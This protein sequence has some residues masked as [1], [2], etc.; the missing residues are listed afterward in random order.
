[1]CVFERARVGKQSEIARKRRRDIVG[2]REREH[3]RE[4]ARAKKT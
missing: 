3:A 4:S 2:E 1:V